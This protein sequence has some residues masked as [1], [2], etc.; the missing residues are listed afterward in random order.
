MPIVVQ[1]ALAQ[2]VAANQDA[3]YGSANQPLTTSI[4]GLVNGETSAPSSA[5]R[6]NWRPPP[7]RRPR[8]GDL[9]DHACEG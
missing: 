7:W 8:R 1:K 9:P 6:P 3:T 4:A 5:A 2:I